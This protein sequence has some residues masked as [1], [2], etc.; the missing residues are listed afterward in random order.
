[1]EKKAYSPL[2]EAALRLM[3]KD[4]P[5]LEGVEGLARQ[6]GVSKYHLIR[7]F[8][9]ETGLS[10]GVYLQ[11]ARLKAACLLLAGRSYPIETVAEMTGFSSSSYFGKVFRKA[12]GKSPAEYRLAHRK[13][14]LIWEEELA[15][16][17]LESIFHL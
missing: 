14:E 8:G 1:M 5:F 9:R 3:E 11:Q 16:Q 13:E 17:E 15:V 4:F 6:L 2:V 7:V 12:K 10:P